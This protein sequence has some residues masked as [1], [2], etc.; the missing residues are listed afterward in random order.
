MSPRVERLLSR[1]EHRAKAASDRAAAKWK[2]L[3][4]GW[5]DK[6]RKKFWDSLTSRAPKHKVTECIEKMKDEPGIDDAGAFCAALADR[7]L[8]TTE[9]RGKDRSA[10]R[11]REA[12]RLL[13]EAASLMQPLRSRRDY[14]ERGDGREHSRVPGDELPEQDE[15]NLERRR[16]ASRW[17]TRREMERLCPPCAERMRRAGF[18]K[19]HASV[20]RRMMASGAVGQGD[21]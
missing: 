2:S 21:R 6:S 4:K 7:V 18:T 1:L 17:I 15:T 13:R 8:G 14:G 19:V 11:R 10:S 5:T 12:R 20:L 3:P 16:S 9:W